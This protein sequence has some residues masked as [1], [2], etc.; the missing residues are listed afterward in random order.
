[1]EFFKIDEI[2]SG[3]FHKV[4]KKVLWP[5][6]VTIIIA[7]AIQ[8]AVIWAYFNFEMRNIKSFVPIVSMFCIVFICCGI[9]EIFR[10][11]RP[12]NW[13]LTISDDNIYIKFRSCLYEHLARHKKGIISLKP[14]EIEAFRETYIIDTIVTGRS[15]RQIKNLYLDISI[16]DELVPLQEAL[17]NEHRNYGFGKVRKSKIEVSW[18]DF[19]VTVSK[20]NI[21]RI[22][23][24]GISPSEKSL[25]VELKNM[26]I[27]ELKSSKEVFNFVNLK[28]EPPNDVIRQR[29]VEL[30]KEGRRYNAR[31][32]IEYFYLISRKQTND[33]IEELVQEYILK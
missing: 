22:N 30:L 9:N 26:G 29:I 18:L 32:A 25:F 1:M 16:H 20:E 27:K 31:N 8:I 24:T 13:L 15:K 12:S 23:I 21:I 5:T 33:M 6:I 11:L 19:P 14:S 28:R 7:L 4:F 3:T 2:D 17:A 10:K